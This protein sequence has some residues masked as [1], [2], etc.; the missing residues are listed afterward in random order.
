MFNPGTNRL[1]RFSISGFGQASSCRIRSEK[2]VEMLYIAE[3]QQ[4][5]RPMSKEYNGRGV[6]IVPAQSLLKLMEPYLI[7]E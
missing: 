7:K 6:L 4:S 2:G 5:N 3:L 1:M